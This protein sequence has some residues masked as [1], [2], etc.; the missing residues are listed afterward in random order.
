M[1]KIILLLMSVFALNVTCVYAQELTKK[2]QKE[3]AEQKKKAEK[4]KQE[5]EK[6]RAKQAKKEAKRAEQ[7][8][9]FVQMVNS[10]EHITIDTKNVAQLDSLV[11]HLNTM[12]VDV[13]VLEK[14][15]QSVEM[16][17]EPYVDED[18][19]PDTL[20]Y[21]RDKETQQRFTNEE[22]EKLL[23]SQRNTVRLQNVRAATLVAEGVSAAAAIASVP[24]MSAL[25]K[26]S[27]AAEASSLLKQS[28]VIKYGLAS[29]NYHLKK[30]MEYLGFQLD[31]EGDDASEAEL[32][33]F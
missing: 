27:L 14:E 31:N 23:K 26:L 29:M 13:V 5:A 25:D 19:I 7:F 1:K 28:K 4:A 24:G 6:E 21:A 15:Y 20:W 8:A 10:Y 2:E 11:K 22:A 16:V 32:D 33:D 18:G 12:M 17:S 3:Q 9:K 30:N